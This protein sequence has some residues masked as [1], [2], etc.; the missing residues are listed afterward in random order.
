MN[1]YHYEVR[2]ANGALIKCF[3]NDFQS[4]KQYASQYDGCGLM[5]GLRVR[6]YLV[7]A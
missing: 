5:Y 7:R 2:N 1:R 6:K 4:A 3:G